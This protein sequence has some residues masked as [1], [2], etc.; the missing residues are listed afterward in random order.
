MRFRVERRFVFG[1]SR[2]GSGCFFFDGLV[3]GCR[4]EVGARGEVGDG[5]FCDSGGFSLVRVWLLRIISRRVVSKNV[6][7]IAVAL[8]LFRVSFVFSGR[9]LFGRVLSS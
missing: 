3:G 7:G 5:V 4:E 9:G 1:G 2:V 8:T 6:L